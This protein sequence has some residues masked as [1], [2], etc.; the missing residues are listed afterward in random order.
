MTVAPLGPVCDAGVG[1]LEVARGVSM[2]AQAV[3]R[4]VVLPVLAVRRPE[5][6]PLV[7]AEGN[8]Q[9]L[10][11]FMLVAVLKTGDYL[12]E[13]PWWNRQAGMLTDAVDQINLGAEATSGG[14]AL[15]GACGSR[16]GL[17]SEC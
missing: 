4:A 10:R 14:V 12:A 13:E 8:G 6:A 17:P 7:G 5:D 15:G 11:A 16:I 9:L 1:E 2:A 3:G